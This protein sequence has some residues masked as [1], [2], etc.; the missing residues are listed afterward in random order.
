MSILFRKKYDFYENIFCGNHFN[1][2]R[3]YD[4]I[5]TRLTMINTKKGL[6][7]QET[8]LKTAKQLFYENGF[9]DVSLNDICT[10]SNKKLGT[11]TYYFPKKWNIIATLYQQYMD[12]I[13]KFV[14][15]NTEDIS[16]AERYVYVI[17]MYYFNIY[18]D[19]ALTRF[20]CGVMHESS[21]NDIFYDTKQF[22]DPLLKEEIDE[23]L[24]VLYIKA[25]NA[26]RREL[27]LAF[28]RDSKPH[29]LDEI[30]ALVRQIHLVSIRLYGFD[31]NLFDEYLKKG[32]EFVLSHP[33]SVKLIEE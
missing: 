24:L 3:N 12:K 16:P 31:I 8:I 13:Q 32:R 28:M 1:F 29:T 4:I 15:E 22:V 19:E 2:I 11:L 26:V 23:S 7:T 6:N 10:R 17:M 21:M 14:K 18:A 5:C 33:N 25:D 20:H 9:Y 30:V 27:N